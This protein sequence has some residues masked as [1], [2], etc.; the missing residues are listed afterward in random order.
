MAESTFPPVTQHEPRFQKR[1]SSWLYA[2]FII[3]FCHRSIKAI[4]SSRASFRVILSRVGK[5]SGTLEYV[6]HK[7]LL[8]HDDVTV[9][10]DITSCLLSH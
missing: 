9:T 8:M 2:D 3:L 7:N 6:M 4:S 10:H 1:F 5:V